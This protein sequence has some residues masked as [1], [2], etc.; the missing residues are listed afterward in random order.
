MTSRPTSRRTRWLAVGGAVVATVMAAVLVAGTVSRAA[1]NGPAPAACTLNASPRR[2]VTDALSR[3]RAGTLPAAAT[4]GQLTSVEARLRN[5][6]RQAGDDDSR[7]Q[8]QDLL[9]A[10]GPVRAA[11]A[12]GADQSPEVLAVLDD[13]LAVLNRRCPA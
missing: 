2:D 7:Q 5:L 11:V 3:F 13:M 1:G 4:A 12:T 8:L 6:V 10:V 9:D